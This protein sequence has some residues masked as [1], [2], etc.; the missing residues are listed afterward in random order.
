M[1]QPRPFV[2]HRGGATDEAQRRRI[3]D[4]WCERIARDPRLFT[5]LESSSGQPRVVLGDA[6]LSLLVLLGA[7]ALVLLI[8]CAN[9]ANLLL[10]RTH[11]RA[12][13][14]ALRGALGASR[15]RVIQQL[16]GIEREPVPVEG[17]G[18]EA[19]ADWDHLGTPETY[20]GY[21]RGERFASAEE[22][23]PNEARAYELP[24][25]LRSNQWALAGVWTIGR[26]NVVLEEAGGSIAFQFD[27]R[28][29]HLVLSPG[30]H[31]PIPFRVLVDGKPPGPSHFCSLT[32]K[33]R[34][35]CWNVCVNTMRVCCTSITNSC[36]RRSAAKTPCCTLTESTPPMPCW[37]AR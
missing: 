3:L 34:R 12:K 27:A 37:T 19:E 6:R 16:L 13:E 5:L 20:L 33:A 21:G 36:A 1:Q 35:D 26:E 28:D 23:A 14:I 29:A 24:E 30:T 8:A 4:E 31:E 17:F 9:L 10:V 32:L 25:R 2:H 11:G 18:V 7:V 22:A 15:A